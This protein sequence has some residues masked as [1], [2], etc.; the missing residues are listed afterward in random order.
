[1]YFSSWIIVRIEQYL[2]IICYY[3]LFFKHRPKMD[4]KLYKI[5]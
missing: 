1:M 2:N 3:F 5:V 4:S